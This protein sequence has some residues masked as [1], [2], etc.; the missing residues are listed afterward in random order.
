[1]SAAELSFWEEEY[2]KEYIGG[3][4]DDWRAGVVA[5]AV[6]NAAGLKEGVTPYR[7]SDFVGLCRAEKEDIS[8]NVGERLPPE[9]EMEIV[10]ASIMNRQRIRGVKAE[11]EGKEGV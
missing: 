9:D 4:R 11:S 7:G 6:Y 2:S 10:F 8:N 5:S 1:M 3:D